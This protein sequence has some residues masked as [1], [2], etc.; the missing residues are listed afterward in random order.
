MQLCWKGWSD[1]KIYISDT[2]SYSL[3]PTNK[4]VLKYALMTLKTDGT[5]DT[6]TITQ[7]E[8]AQWADSVDADGYLYV[9]FANTQ[10]G[11]LFVMPKP[12]QPTNP[13]AIEN[14]ADASW[15]VQYVGNTVVVTTTTDQTFTL[16][17][18]LGSV[19]RHWTQPASTTE[20]V[21]LPTSGVYVL[22]GGNRTQILCK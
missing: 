22:K 20:E 5:C 1:L 3:T 4:H 8:M 13:T 21:L 16:Y 6:L 7:T 10:Y 11:D 2:C 9:R 17:S 15:Q 19:L 18:A 14:T 12:I